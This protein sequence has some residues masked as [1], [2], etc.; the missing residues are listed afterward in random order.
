LTGLR[1]RKKKDRKKRIQT[2]AIN[3]FSSEGY[4]STRVEKIAEKADV[5]VGTL[6]NYYQS[7]GGLLLS[8]IVDRY[9]RISREMEGILE[10]SH[11]NPV[12]S[13]QRLAQL[14]IKSFSV[15]SKQLWREFIGT[16]LAHEPAFL[17]RIMEMDQRFIA[18]M[19]ELLKR[20]QKH[21]TI[22]RSADPDEMALF[23][24]GSII[25]HVLNYMSD[26][27]MTIRD[28]KESLN[29]NIEISYNGLKN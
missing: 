5:G 12:E 24:Y 14:Y 1:E 25:F 16:A 13:I 20:L 21:N 29:R 11:Q 6:Y 23:I 8:I 27:K 4:G 3:L 19:I 9:D 22:S 28:L 26:K 18:Q 17:D 15:Y 2:A 7:K 10:N